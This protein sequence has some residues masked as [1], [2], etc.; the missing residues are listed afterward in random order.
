MS[1]LMYPEI[2]DK[3]ALATLVVIPREKLDSV[4]D[5]AIYV[6]RVSDL[7]TLLT[8]FG[9]LYSTLKSM[10]LGYQSAGIEFSTKM[11]PPTY[12]V[13]PAKLPENVAVVAIQEKLWVDPT[14]ST[15]RRVTFEVDIV[16]RDSHKKFRRII[17]I[18][19]QHIISDVFLEE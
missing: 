3:R 6:L 4:R 2:S 11:T 18:R 15:H 1:V 14:D 17:T 12:F 7:K 10:D 5:Y 13:N 16:T 8:E 9:K 19:G